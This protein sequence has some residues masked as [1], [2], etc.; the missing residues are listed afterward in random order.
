[1]S[2]F[3]GGIF[4][5]VSTDLRL[6][7]AVFVATNVKAL[8]TKCVKKNCNSNVQKALSGIKQEALSA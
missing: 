7:L 5:I 8:F 1:M 6:V 4:D 2:R 3:V